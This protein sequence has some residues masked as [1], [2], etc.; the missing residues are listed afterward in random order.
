MKWG[1]ETYPD[2]EVNTDESPVVFKAQLYA[3]T[4]VLPERQKVMLK[5]VTLKDS[6]WNNFNLKDV[7]ILSSQC[8]FQ[9]NLF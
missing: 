1:K 5:G 2:I 7:C 3:L 4:G 6:D 9:S 8:Y